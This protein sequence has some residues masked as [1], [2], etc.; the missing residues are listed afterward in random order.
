MLAG[1]LPS[2]NQN[3]SGLEPTLL[4]SAYAQVKVPDEMK[5]NRS[6]IKNEIPVDFYMTP[7]VI[8]TSVY[9][10]DG[11]GCK[12]P[13]PVIPGEPVSLKPASDYYIIY[14]VGEK[15]IDDNGVEAAAGDGLWPLKLADP[16]VREK[17]I[18]RF[19]Q[20]GEPVSGRKLDDISL[21]LQNTRDSSYAYLY[22]EGSHPRYLEDANGSS[23]THST[24][25][26]AKF[27]LT[28][29]QEKT[30]GR[31]YFNMKYVPFAAFNAADW[32]G[33]N[34]TTPPVWK[35]RNGLNDLPPLSGEA[36]F[37]NTFDAGA[38]AIPLVVSE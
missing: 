11:A 19:Y 21:T 33:V 30:K 28:T 3:G 20:H 23:A 22:F 24:T 12:T 13:V 32:S 34:I 1:H 35:I 2:H 18:W 4:S 6:N 5:N 26:T 16:S 29:P 37:D 25:G 36:G 17:N 15:M 9:H 8:D 38:G 7:A 27:G 14:H 10:V 31:V